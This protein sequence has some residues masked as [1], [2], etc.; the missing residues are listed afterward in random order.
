LTVITQ[1]IPAQRSNLSDRFDPRRRFEQVYPDLTAL[2]EPI[3][4]LTPTAAALHLL[5]LAEHLFQGRMP[6]F[7]APAVTATRVYLQTIERGGMK[8]SS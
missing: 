1:H 7:P 5:D 2:L 6:A 4:T 8:E 3:H